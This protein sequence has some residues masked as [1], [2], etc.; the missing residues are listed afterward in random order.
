MIRPRPAFDLQA[1]HAVHSEA[2]VEWRALTV[3]LIER[4]L[5]PVRAKLKRDASF[6]LPHLLEGGTWSAGRKI[7]LALRPPD[8]PPPIS[9]AADGTVF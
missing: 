8:G 4:L 2:I 3:A 5:E 9:V 7:A 1:R 6:S